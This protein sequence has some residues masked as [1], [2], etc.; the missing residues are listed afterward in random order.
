MLDLS[1]LLQTSLFISER[2]CKLYAV[3]LVW[4]L[5]G[6]S[7]LT[8]FGTRGNQIFRKTNLFGQHNFLKLPKS[9]QQNVHIFYPDNNF[10]PKTIHAQS[11]MWQVNELQL[12]THCTRT[13]RVKAEIMN[14]LNLSKRVQLTVIQFTNII[15][16]L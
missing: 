7:L 12:F 9:F 6:G 10:S 15:S 16:K 1:Q 2:Y 8:P 14:V 4:L 5:R 3:S 13:Y 11:N